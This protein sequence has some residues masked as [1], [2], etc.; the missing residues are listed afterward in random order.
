MRYFTMIKESINEEKG[1]LRCKWKTQHLHNCSWM[2][3]S[4]PSAADR[5]DGKSV[6]AEKASEGKHNLDLSCN[7]HRNQKD[8]YSF[9]VQINVCQ[10]RSWL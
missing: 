7:M 5:P 2:C 1:H 10:V 3:L 8:V 6:R 9:K 4:H